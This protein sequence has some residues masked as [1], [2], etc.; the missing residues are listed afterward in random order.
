MSIKQLFEKYQSLLDERRDN[1]KSSND[2]IIKNQEI[3]VK[4]NKLKD[5]L[6]STIAKEME[7]GKTLY[8]ICMDEF[9]V[10]DNRFHNLYLIFVNKIK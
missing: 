10:V 4:T 5:E 6:V 8:Q 2:L 3:K 7:A 9:G 1:R